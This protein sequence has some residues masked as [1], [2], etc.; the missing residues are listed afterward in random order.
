[1]SIAANLTTAEL[2]S[3]MTVS[4]NNWSQDIKRTVREWLEVR[5]D[6]VSMSA[7]VMQNY[8]YWRDL[9]VIDDCLNAR[10]GN[11]WWQDNG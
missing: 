11:R 1:M 2:S 4:C 7:D 5:R 6:I 3:N 10:F 9:K 8:G